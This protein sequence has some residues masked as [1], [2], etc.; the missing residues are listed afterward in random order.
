MNDDGCTVFCGVALGGSRSTTILDAEGKLGR[1]APLLVGSIRPNWRGRGLFDRVGAGE[2]NA[3]ASENS[4]LEAPRL[5]M[6][7][8]LLSKG[9]ILFER[10][11]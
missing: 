7:S 11:V 1:E 3:L 8:R 5:E 2:S 9:L 6:L 4:E 10:G